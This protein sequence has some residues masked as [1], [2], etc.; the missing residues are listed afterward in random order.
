M[1]RS[2]AIRMSQASAVSSPPASAQPLTAATIGFAIR[3][4]P[5]VKPLRPS[6]TI[7]RISCRGRALDDRR[8]VGL[9]VGAGAERVAGAGEDRDVDRVVVGEVG[10]GLDHQPVD[11]GVDRVAGLGAVDRHPGDP[12]ALLVQHLAHLGL[13]SSS[14]VDGADHRQVVGLPDDLAAAPLGL[15][16]GGRGQVEALGQRARPGA[17]RHR[18][19]RRRSPASATARARGGTGRACRRRRGGGST[20]TPITRSQGPSGSGSSIRPRRISSQPSW[21]ALN[22]ISGLESRP[23]IRV[24][25]KRSSRR[26]VVSAVPKPSSRIALGRERD[27]LD[28]PRPGARRSAGRRRG[29]SPRRSRGR[30]GTVRGGRRP[31]SSA[32]LISVRE[33]RWRPIQPL[34]W[35]GSR[36]APGDGKRLE[37][38]LEPGEVEL[39]GHAYELSP[40][41]VVRR[42]SRS[43]GPRPATRCGCAFE[44]ELAGPCMR[45]LGRRRCHGRGRGARG[46]PAGTDDEELRSPYVAEGELDLDAWAHDALVLAMPQQLL[47]RPDCAGLCPVCG[48]SLNDAEPG[49]HDHPREPDPRWAK[50]RELQ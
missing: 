37:L 39:G 33:L 35:P 41:V 10:P 28:R 25:G 21:R 18:R 42:A 5:R 3:C 36:P 4:M 9:Q 1:A 30:S 14:V 38:E 43:R 34:S 23:V 32:S 17:R 22:T 48:E 31:G 2:E 46:R 13:L 12:V 49:A 11:V 24:S 20:S 27:R 19:R 50:L 26:W 6:S 7:S 47:C 44:A 8:D 16:G 15:L 45:C 29:S 40:A